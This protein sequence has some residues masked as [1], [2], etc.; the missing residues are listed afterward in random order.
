MV[1]ETLH[2]IG[3]LFLIL[4]YIILFTAK[5]E[6][7]KT[8]HEVG[9]TYTINLNKEHYPWYMP[10]GKKETLKEKYAKNALFRN[11]FLYITDEDELLWHSIRGDLYEVVFKEIKETEL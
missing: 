3:D 11:T 5:T 6:S 2:W 10:R 7:H 9:G 1:T 8:W 4:A